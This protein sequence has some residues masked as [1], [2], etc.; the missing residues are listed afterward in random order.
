MKSIPE[1]L[2]GYKWFC[3]WL[4]L[5]PLLGTPA[6]LFLRSKRLFSHTQN[7]LQYLLCC[8][9]LII[10]CLEAHNLHHWNRH[11]L[12]VQAHYE[13]LDRMLNPGKNFAEGSPCAIS[14]ENAKASSIPLCVMEENPPGEAEKKHYAHQVALFFRLFGFVSALAGMEFGRSLRRAGYSSPESWKILIT[15][16]IA[17]PYLQWHMTQSVD[18]N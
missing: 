13:G 1:D 7:Q 17:V 4:L 5:T 18:F 11:R 6:W 8:A 10:A 16:Y 15:S 2:K 14:P 3:Y 12:R 9:L